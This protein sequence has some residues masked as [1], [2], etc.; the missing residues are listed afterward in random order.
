MIII[1][2][3]IIIQRRKNIDSVAI[4]CPCHETESAT[5]NFL[6]F[7]AVQ[8]LY[9]LLDFFV[10]ITDF[11]IQIAA[12]SML[13]DCLESIGTEILVAIHVSDGIHE[14]TQDDFHVIGKVEL[15][16]AICEM[17][18]DSAHCS[19]PGVEMR[20]T[21]DRITLTLDIIGTG[22]D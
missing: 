14:W 5:F 8:S 21:R 10:C 20:N 7:C 17:H 22:F 2:I 9:Q 3:L 15:D 12:A 16:S 1:N 19:K 11:L 13:H 4:A 6:L 18:H